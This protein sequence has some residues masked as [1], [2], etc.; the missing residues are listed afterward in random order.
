VACSEKCTDASS[1]DAAILDIHDRKGPCTYFSYHPRSRLCTL[2]HGSCA[3]I[4]TPPEQR[5]YR[6]LSTNYVGAYEKDVVRNFIKNCT[7]DD[8]VRGHCFYQATLPVP[9]LQCQ[10]D[11]NFG[12]SGGAAAEYVHQAP[13]KQMCPWNYPT[14]DTKDGA[15]YCR[16]TDT[17]GTIQCNACESDNREN[18]VPGFK[19][20]QHT[21]PNLCMC[22]ASPPIRTGTGKERYDGN[23]QYTLVDPLQNVSMQFNTA[24]WSRSFETRHSCPPP[25]V[26]RVDGSVCSNDRG[27]SCGE[28]ATCP[29]SGRCLTPTGCADYVPCGGSERGSCHI[30]GSIRRWEEGKRATGTSCKA[31]SVEKPMHTNITL[32]EQ[33]RICGEYC[34]SDYDCIN[35]PNLFAV[36]NGTC[37]LCKGIHTN[38]TEGWVLYSV[39]P[40]FEKASCDCKERWHGRSCTCPIPI[41]TKGTVSDGYSNNFRRTT[42]EWCSGHGVCCPHD[43]SI[44]L[45]A[46]ECTFADDGCVCDDG[47]TGPMCTCTQEPDICG[48]NGLSWSAS[49]LSDEY[50]AILQEARERDGV[51]YGSQGCTVTDCMCTANYTGF[52]CHARIGAMHWDPTRGVMQRW[53]CGEQSG[54]GSWLRTETNRTKLQKCSCAA[55]DDIHADGSSGRLAI[56]FTGDACQCAEIR[57]RNET[58]QM[59]GGHGTCI[60]PSMPNGQCSS[61]LPIVL[62]TNQLEWTADDYNIAVE[63]LEKLGQRKEWGASPPTP[64]NITGTYYDT[65]WDWDVTDGTSRPTATQPP[66]TRFPG[67]TAPNAPTP[68]P[69][70]D[71]STSTRCV[72]CGTG[73]K[74]DWIERCK[75]IC[76]SMSYREGCI[77]YH[78][79]DGNPPV[80]CEW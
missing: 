29:G 65:D 77:T 59:C 72:P 64:I 5:V 63:E 42:Q 23:D 12:P 20:R 54:R 1:D 67:H 21:P 3:R 15:N 48:G 40:S 52:N 14:M 51:D 28:D 68:P 75:S 31:L 50:K 43:Q 79:G 78:N 6:R 9:Q 57:D 25:R 73:A 7:M 32:R 4:D 39:P 13:A 66:T 17:N 76:A 41:P 11:P 55:F 35:G 19:N 36:N 33:V 44:N 10:C 46:H 8:G 30:G 18:I 16:N 27:R 37:Q 56:R 38:I 49:F 62:P 80:G 58:F 24:S 53:V 26:P 74:M 70:V 45:D 22:P 71:H 61:Y 69:T 2:R 60:E 47:Y 34:M